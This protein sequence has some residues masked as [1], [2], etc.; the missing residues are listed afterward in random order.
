CLCPSGYTGVYCE[1]DIDYCVHSPCSEHGVC[2]D[3]QSNF[4][5]R[6]ML[7]FEG[8]LCEV[9][10]NECISFPC[11]N[12][13]TCED[14]ISDYRCHCLLGFERT[15]SQNVN[16]CWSQ[17]CLNGGSCMDLINDYICHCPLDQGKDCSSS[18]S[19]CVS[20]PCDPE[21]TIFC[22]ELEST[23]RCLCH[24]GYTGTHCKTRLNHCVDGLCQHGSVC[25]N[26]SGGFKCDCLPLTGQFCEI[27]IDNCA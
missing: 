26:L 4:T 25:E 15:C 7:G 18:L 27:N 2:L 14:L 22:E 13:A 1:L 20:N 3:Q 5:C 19:Q 17:P 16:D 10:A 8:P 11:S 6:C 21:G 23:Y 12:G 24:H 9:E